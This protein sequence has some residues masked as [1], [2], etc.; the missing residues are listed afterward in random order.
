MHKDLSGLAE[1]LYR[2]FSMRT[3]EERTNLDFSGSDLEE[4]RGFHSRPPPEIITYLRAK[5]EGGIEA[6]LREYHNLYEELDALVV[7]DLR[8][9]GAT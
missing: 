7:V 2:Y 9:E 6:W 8:E 1:F 3:P 4:S 5:K